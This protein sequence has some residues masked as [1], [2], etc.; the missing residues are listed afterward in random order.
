MIA[1]GAGTNHWFHSDQIYRTFFTL[2]MLC[3]CQ[4]S[5]AAAGRT[6]SGKRRCAR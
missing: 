3:G 4:G 6:M 1:M 5:T 2:T